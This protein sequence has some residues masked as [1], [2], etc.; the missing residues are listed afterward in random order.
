LYA[1]KGTPKPVADKIVASMQAALKD[2]DLV[3][4]FT[5]LGSVIVAPDRQTPDALGK[6][7][8]TEIDKWAPIIK[9]AGEYAD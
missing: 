1:P 8:K 6:Y 3:K 7:L 9:K 2:P 4:R 5:D